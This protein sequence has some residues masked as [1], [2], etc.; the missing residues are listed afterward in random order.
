M[1]AGFKF[2]RLVVSCLTFGGWGFL[3]LGV[4]D[5]YVWVSLLTIGG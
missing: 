2:L 1:I 5:Y 3:R 4:R